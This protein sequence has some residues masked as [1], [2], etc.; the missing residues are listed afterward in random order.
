MT[1]A[2]IKRILENNE[3]KQKM[4]SLFGKKQDAINKEEIKEFLNQVNNLLNPPNSQEQSNQPEPI[5]S[6]EQS[7]IEEE[8]AVTDF[9]VRTYVISTQ[10]YLEINNNELHYETLIRDITALKEFITAKFKANRIAARIADM[11]N[12][13]Y[14]KILSSKNNGSAIGQLKPQIEQ[15]ALNPAIFGLEVSVFAAGVL[16]NIST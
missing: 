4:I 15:I 14:K 1:F 3:A 16:K 13:S 7:A 8:Q 9:P 11:K 10:M 12:F 6:A 2:V 5:A